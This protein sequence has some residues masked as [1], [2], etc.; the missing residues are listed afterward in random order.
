MYPEEQTVIITTDADFWTF[1]TSADWIKVKTDRAATILT[2][3]V[4]NHTNTY[5]SRTGI[6]TVMAGDAPPVTISIT[7]NPKI[8]DN[9]SVSPTSLIFEANE[10]QSKTVVVT[11]DA[12][13]WDAW[14]SA[15]WVTVTKSGK[16]ANVRVSNN[17]TQMERTATVTIRAGDAENKTF[18]VTQRVGN[19]LSVDK[20]SLIF[21][22]N[23]T[24]AQTI[25]ITTN[26]SDWS[27]SHPSSANWISVSLNGKVVS[28]RPTSVNTDVRPRY[29]MLTIEAGNAIPVTVS[30]TQSVS[31]ATASIQ[32][33]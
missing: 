6:I 8:Q 13:I 15:S 12:P 30:V 2:I 3:N 27:V 24:V 7:Q 32:N 21:A 14:P 26:A 11:T 9:L 19:T 31:A 16:N 22:S 28:I 18:T 4:E 25:T 29:T 17:N 5:D 33:P 20:T 1:Q 23:S 10:T